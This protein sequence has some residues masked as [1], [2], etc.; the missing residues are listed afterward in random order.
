MRFLERLA[1]TLEKD[2]DFKS[3]TKS[4]DDLSSNYFIAMVAVV[5]VMMVAVIRK[6][7]EMYDDFG[8]E[9]TWLNERFLSAFLI[10]WW[11]FWWVM[12]LIVMAWHNCFCVLT[13]N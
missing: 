1:I 12:L 3:Q 9:F 2:K 7:T 6:L 4:C 13:K 8:A 10:L 5:V 11:Q